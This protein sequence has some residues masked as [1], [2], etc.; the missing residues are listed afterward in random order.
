[1]RQ[2]TERRDEKGIKIESLADRPEFV[3]TVAGWHLRWAWSL[4]RC[5]KL[6]RACAQP[7]LLPSLYVALLGSD[8]LE[9]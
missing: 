3:S 8:P 7:G 9:R 1:M 5:I 6:A 2:R 4:H